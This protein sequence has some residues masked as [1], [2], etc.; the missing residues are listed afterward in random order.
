MRNILLLIA[1]LMATS[2]AITVPATVTANDAAWSYSGETG[3]AHWASL[4]NDYALCASGEN[5]SPINIDAATT[6]QGMKPGI[7]FNYGSIIPETIT[8]TGNHIQIAVGAGANIKV[9]DTE[10]E[11]QSLIVRTPSENTVNGKHFPMELQFVHQSKDQELAYVSMM[12]VPGRPDRALNKLITQ[13]PTKAGESKQLAANTLKTLEKKKKLASYY[14]YAGSMTTP[15]CTEGVRWY[16]MND[17]LTIS[18]NQLKAFKSV[19]KQDNNRPVQDLNA[20]MV[21]R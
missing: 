2:F 18:D 3:P 6:L 4:S 7:K 9:E 21:I 14:Y 8:N 10:F 15:P 20:R 12:F 5:Q 16:I 11:L 1:T 13:L 19:I 17:P